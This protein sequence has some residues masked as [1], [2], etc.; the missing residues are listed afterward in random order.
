[1]LAPCMVPFEVGV[2]MYKHAGFFIGPA[3]WFM[4]VPVGE[5]KC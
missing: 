2:N 3:V 5:V 4:S 1:M